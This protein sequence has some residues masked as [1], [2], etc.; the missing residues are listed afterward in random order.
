MYRPKI[1]A[2][3]ES[4][5]QKVAFANWF[6]QVVMMLMTRNL[7]VIAGRGAAKTTE[8]QTE[9]LIEMI[10]DMPGAPVCWVAD[11]YTNL[12]KNVLPMVLEGLER[13]GYIENVHYVIEKAPPRYTKKEKESLPENLRRHFW[14]PFNKIVSYKHKLIFYTGLNVT[15]GSLDRPSSLAGNSYVHIFGDEVKY[16]PEHKFANLMKAVRGYALQ[17]GNSIFYRGV[18]LTTDM[19]NPANI[20]EYDWINKQAKRMNKGAIVRLL[21]CSMVLNEILGEI[22]VATEKRDTRE[23]QRLELIYN[24]WKHRLYLARRTPESHTFYCRV[25]S[26]VNADILTAE[27]F[28]DAFESDLGDINTAILSLKPTLEGGER[29]YAN[30]TSSHFYRDGNRETVAEDMGL[31][32]EEDCRILEYL[33][34]DR[35]LDMSVDFGNMFSMLIAQS[36]GEYYR[37]LKNIY[38]LSPEWI[39]DLTNEFL[40]YF[41]HHEK[42]RIDLYYDRAGNNYSKAK[43]DLAT[44]LKHDLEYDS[45]GR[46]TGWIVTLKSLCQG[47]IGQSEE[48]NFMQELL[49]GQNPGLPKVQIDYYN[50]KQL[51]LSLE[52]A[53]TRINRKG[54]VYKDKRSE[55]LP[56]DRLPNESTNFSDA[57]KYLMMRPTFRKSAG[58]RSPSYLPD[59]KT[60]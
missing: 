16:F 59:P 12:Q 43:Q 23:V 14:K 33:Q 27:W 60:Y 32:E 42:K 30:L 1:K 51:R 10:Y 29:F 57:F 44:A 36:D 35:P 49:G 8:I 55:S 38:T 4:R 11:T 40:R 7:Y 50:C 37:V 22:I 45:V 13:K 26:Y 48:Y 41:K 47:N 34:R 52:G 5:L 58:R 46:R 25:S 24:R 39:R 3:S 17:F 53:R 9:R 20:G 18:T 28:S 56:I 2:D 21:Q 54:M 19:P 6:S 15:F 31:L